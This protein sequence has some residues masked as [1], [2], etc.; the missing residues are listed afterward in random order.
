MKLNPLTNAGTYCG[1]VI[2]HAVNKTDDGRPQFV[3]K[4][5]KT[6]WY[7][8]EEEEW[9]YDDNIRGDEIMAGLDLILPDQ[10]GELIS[11]VK[12]VMEIFGW[13][14]V[15]LIDLD[16]LK[17]RGTEIQFEVIERTCTCGDKINVEVASIRGRDD[18]PGDLKE[19]IMRNSKNKNYK[20]R[21]S[22][23]R[24]RLNFCMVEAVDKLQKIFDWNR[25]SSMPTSW[26][27]LDEDFN[28][29]MK[30]YPDI[31]RIFESQL[32][33]EVMM[34]NDATEFI[35]KQ[36]YFELRVNDPDLALSLLKTPF[37]SLFS[38]KL[39]KSCLDLVKIEW[40]EIK[41]KYKSTKA[42]KLAAQEALAAIAN[43]DT[44]ICNLCHIRFPATSQYFYKIAS[45]NGKFEEICK[46]CTFKGIEMYETYGISLTTTEAELAD[47]AAKD[48]TEWRKYDSSWENKQA[49]I[50]DE[51]PAK[52]VGTDFVNEL[53]R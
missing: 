9:V 10:N 5:R 33:K 47:V 1:I 25:N 50:Y 41:D 37:P 53:V 32:N 38:F 6:S 43:V 39:N 12:S 18:E 42:L 26:D 4:L 8:F 45:M 40:A 46:T 23:L 20:T 22:Q 31:E 17:L 44:R 15:S 27:D 48:Y 52:N 30:Q 49:E 14:G 19:R 16:A 29:V 28:A 7:D 36:E 35:S 13:N 21:Q 2:E 34:V 11:H 24:Q 3:M 51:A